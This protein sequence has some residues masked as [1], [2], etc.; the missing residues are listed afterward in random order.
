MPHDTVTVFAHNVRSVS[1]YIGDIV[2]GDRIINNGIIGLTETQIN[3]SDSTCKIMET[4]I[5]F[6]INFNNDD[7]KFLSLAYA[8]RNNVA[9][10]DKFDVS[11][12]SVF[13]F[14][15]HAFADRL[16]TLVLVYR[17]KSMQMQEFSRM[18]QYLV[19]IYSIDIIAGNFNYDLLRKL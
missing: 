13:I 6:N 2:S 4:L 12:V 9:I 19:A 14:K 15:K 3:Q 8:C 16:F 18:L 7:N 17:N 10:L 11:G 5:F 1:K